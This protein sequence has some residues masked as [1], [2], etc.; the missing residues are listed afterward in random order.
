MNKSRLKNSTAQTRKKRKQKH[1]PNSEKWMDWKNSNQKKEMLVDSALTSRR[2]VWFFTLFGFDSLLYFSLVLWFF[3]LRSVWCQLKLSFRVFVSGG[4]VFISFSRVFVLIPHIYTAIQSGQYNQQSRTNN[5]SLFIS[6]HWARYFLS[7]SLFFSSWHSAS[8]D[9]AHFGCFLGVLD[10]CVCVHNFAKRFVMFSR[11]ICIS[12]EKCLRSMVLMVASRA[13][14][15]S[16]E[17]REKR[18][19]KRM[20]IGIKESRLDG[21]LLLS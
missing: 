1:S 16:S 6:F 14:Q 2:K 7:F 20:N 13:T 8:I 15:N 3:L 11:N 5:F 18:C 4:F 21:Y 12:D 10:E 17:W 9:R 19:E